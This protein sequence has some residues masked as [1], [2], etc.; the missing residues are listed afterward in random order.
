MNEALTMNEA[1][2]EKLRYCTNLPSIPGIAVRILELANKPDT[3]MVQICE[4]VSMDPALSTK[5][6]RVA[7]SPLYLTRR[8]ATNVR[9]AISLLGTHASIMIALSFS[10]IQSMK[11]QPS[12]AYID[13]SRFWRRA[14]ISALA[15]RALGEKAGLKKLDDLFL[16]GLLQDVGIL[17][18][19]SM[20]PDE[21][22]KL[23]PSSLSHSDL[24]LAERDT[25]G[26]GHD[27]IGY[28]LL[29]RWKLPDYLA[30]SCKAGHG[31]TMEK[32]AVSK[33][34]ACI[35]VSGSIADLF[36]DV[37]SR[38]TATAAANAA[39][40]YLN[41]DSDTLADVIDLIASRMP[42]AEDLFDITLVDA[43]EITV[44][45]AEARDLQL[46]HQLCKT[47]ELERNSQR[48]ALTGAHN[49]GFLDGILQREFELASRNGWP[50]SIA[51][52][53]LDHFKQVNDTHGHPA[54]DSVLVSVVRN[55]QSQ[56][57]PEDVF[58][59]YGGEEFIVMLPGTALEPTLRL[60]SRLKESISN[61]VHL[62]DRG[63]PIKVTVSIGAVTHMENGV[64]FNR[65][66]DL[67]QAVDQ[68]LYAAKN[69]GRNRVEVW[70]NKDPLM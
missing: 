67:I 48:D 24:L 49:R 66:E 62:Q 55:V 32:E 26:D 27:E 42:A 53:D 39:L 25:F 10:L 54:G 21:Y 23:Q 11:E 52:I 22:R 68:A 16:A 4:Y 38:A 44:L 33:M 51:M 9:Q 5:F 61:I 14:M 1:L 57:R 58:A 8:A 2:A 31:L 18:F 28:W 36:L 60:L 20:M 37:G 50:L 30:L 34:S 13:R 47:R 45:M 69:S 65:P 56:L 6:L 29:K 7:S 43:A 3:S 70:K 64:R 46:L 63:T 40:D 59:R 19:D 12:G 35:A 41:M 17:V 15:C